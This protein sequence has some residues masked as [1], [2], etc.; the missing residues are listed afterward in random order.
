MKNTTTET[1]KK[2]FNLD[3]LESAPKAEAG[4]P[5]ELLNPDTGEKL[6]ITITLR[7]SESSTY[8][9]TFRAQVDRRMNNRQTKTTMATMESDAIDLL[10]ACTVGWS[11][12]LI[13]NQEFPFSHDNAVALYTR[14]AWIKR[15][16]DAFVSEEANFRRD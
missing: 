11:G 12:I 14:F 16:A 9:S 5:L 15:Q 4:R 7:G 8:R 1:E 13:G 2:G 3:A 10:A 6:G